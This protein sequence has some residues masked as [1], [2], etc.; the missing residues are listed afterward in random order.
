MVLIYL[1]LSILHAITASRSTVFTPHS[2][3][4]RDATQ[5]YSV[6]SGQMQNA[7]CL[8]CPETVFNLNTSWSMRFFVVVS[9]GICVESGGI[10]AIGII[11]VVASFCWNWCCATLGAYS[12][13]PLSP[14]QPLLVVY[15][16]LSSA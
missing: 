3:A 11:T 5:L 7:N 4:R 15:N 14:I 13:P 2:Y 8:R 1:F 12:D 6:G 9:S 10:G 16:F